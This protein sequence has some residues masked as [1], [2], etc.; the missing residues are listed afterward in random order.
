M[1]VTIRNRRDGIVELAPKHAP[2]DLVQRLLL[3]GTI[4]LGSL[5][6]FVSG[7]MPPEV[8]VAIAASCLAGEVVLGVRAL[9]LRVLHP[10]AEVFELA[11]CR[12]Y[13]R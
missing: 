2:T 3:S 9:A 8:L 10:A 7:T 5:S 4:L 12:S 13:R 6:L 1:D 11:R